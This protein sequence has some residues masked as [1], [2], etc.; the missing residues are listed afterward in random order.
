[1]KFLMVPGGWQGGWVF[2][3]VAAE[4]RREGHRVEA[5]TLSGLEPDVP[6][7]PD[8]PPNLDDHIAQVAGTVERSDGSPL[9]LCGHSYAGLVIAGVADRL[10][11]RLAQLVFIDAYVPD[12]GDSCWS[13]TSDGFRELFIA[14]ARGDGRWVAVPDGLD[15]RARPHPMAS[16]VQS[17]RLEGGSGGTYGRTYISGGAWAGS[18]FVAL[19]ERLRADSGWRVHEIPVGHNIARRDPQGL[20]AVLGALPP[21]P[22]RP[23]DR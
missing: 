17:V 22:A 10:G 4:L 13:L 7:D 14:G 5:V 16:F 19:T 2:D 18:P 23:A 3:A 9:A 8:R 12:D 6:A 15:P 20:A 21:G 1:M 11:D